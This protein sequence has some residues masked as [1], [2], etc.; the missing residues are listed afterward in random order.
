MNRVELIITCENCGHVEHLTA[1]DEEESARL[2]DRFTCPGQCS[3]KYYSYITI[4]Q[5]SIDALA[6]PVKVAQVA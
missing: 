5:V 4:E 3:P 2:I 1:R 6:K